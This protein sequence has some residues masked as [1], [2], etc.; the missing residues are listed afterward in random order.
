MSN[1]RIN[2]LLAK[3][4]AGEASPDEIREL[5]DF[6]RLHPQEQYFQ[7]ILSNWWES[8]IPAVKKTDETE[9][10]HFNRIISQL[11]AKKEEEE[12]TRFPIPHIPGRRRQPWKVWLAA[13]AVTGILL[14]VGSQLN[15]S[16]TETNVQD[17]EIVAQR[18]T[19]SKLLLPDG[20]QVWLNSDSRLSYAN[21]FNDTIREVVLEGEA[22]FD[23]VKDVKRP[24]IVHTSG[25]NIR[26]L[27]TAFNVKSYPQ[28]PTIEATL[29][30]GLIEVEKNN[31]PQ[32][33]RILLK[34]NE[35][36]VYNK[37]QD[38]V[39]MA[40]TAGSANGEGVSDVIKGKPESIFIS[41]LPKN[42]SDS[43]RTETSWVYGKLF[44]EGESFRD[45]APKME[46]WF[47]IKIGFLN[48]KVAGYRFTGVFENENIG[49]A[50]HAL[51][52]TASFKYSINGNE[53]WIDKK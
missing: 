10:E 15:R 5:E 39:V 33:S 6:L 22:Y 51:Q 35:K 53:I 45:L 46:R 17:N 30:R 13:A 43:V 29:V 12:E 40:A 8:G 34:P 28:D 31:Q 41:T 52:L 21:S 3:K 38:M 44:F 19:K 23:V 36:L 37:K 47:N 48:D 1:Q 50:L 18:G 42:I 7:E 4:L 24:F 32:S 49:E 9:D 26:V 25:I 16:S 20:T 14:L 11:P 27:G 2:T